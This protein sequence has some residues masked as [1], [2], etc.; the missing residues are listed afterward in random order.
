[1]YNLLTQFRAFCTTYR[2]GGERT[3]GLI[4]DR[5]MVLESEGPREGALREDEELFQ[6][7]TFTEPA[8][9]ILLI[10]RN[11][12][13]TPTESCESDETEVEKVKP[14]SALFGLS[15][16][17][18][19]KKQGSESRCLVARLALP[20]RRRFVCTPVEQADAGCQAFRGDRK[21]QEQRRAE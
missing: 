7:L 14:F 18:T 19:A 15:D 3:V 13:P 17:L 6:R 20:R 9:R 16:P 10:E 11:P 5:A 8:R 12:W 2:N 1:M 4:F 21:R